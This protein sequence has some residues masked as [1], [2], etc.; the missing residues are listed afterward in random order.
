MPGFA[1]RWFGAAGPPASAALGSPR[2]DASPIG[3]VRRGCFEA[4][5]R[6][7]LVRFADAARRAAPHRPPRRAGRITRVV[8]G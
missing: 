7:S 5:R 8:A 2:R 6:A 1:V 3:G 4:S